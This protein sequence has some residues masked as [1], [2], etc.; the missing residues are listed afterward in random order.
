MTY[1]TAEVDSG[2]GVKVAVDTISTKHYQIFKLATGGEGTATEISSANPVPV[3]DGGGSITVDNGGTFAVQAAQSGTWNVTLSGTPSVAQSGTW[4]LTQITGGVVPGTAATSLGKAVDSAAGSTDTGVAFLGVRDDALTTLTPVDGDYTQARF[5][6]YGALWVNVRNAITGIVDDAA[7]TVGTD[8]V[9]PLGLMADESSTDSVNEGDVGVARMT[10]DRKAI[11]TEYVHAA[12]GGTSGYSALA[13]AAV[14]AAEIKS[15][16]GKVFGI[17]AFNNT[18]SNKYVRLYNQTGSP[19]NTDTAN[20]V[21]RGILP[22]SG[23]MNITFPKGRQFS[24]GIGIRFTGAV[25]DNDNTA[26]SANDL[27]VNVDYV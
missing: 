22:A 14:L 5:D 2:T 15:S 9:L 25:A 23:G 4:S 6:Q 18:S 17:S 11:V 8:T 19:A 27:T 10:L 7:F 21:W 24:T 12:A 26:L 16:A 13:G 20:I 1:A 3:G